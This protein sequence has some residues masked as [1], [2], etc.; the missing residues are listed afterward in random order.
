MVDPPRSAFAD[1]E[2]ACHGRVRGAW[3]EMDRVVT[4]GMLLRLRRGVEN[5]REVVDSIALQDDVPDDPDVRASRL[6]D[7]RQV[8]DTELLEALIASAGGESSGNRIAD[9]M[10]AAIQQTIQATKELPVTVEDVWLPDTLAPKVSDSAGRKFGK[11]V[12]RVVSTARK[13]GE[14]RNAPFQPVALRHIAREVVPAEDQA[15]T[16]ALQE[17][18]RWL[19]DLEGAWIKWAAVALPELARAAE[20]NREDSAEGWAA[21]RDAALGFQST[22]EVLVSESPLSDSVAA[23]ETRLGLAAGVLQA[24]YAVAGSFLLNEPKVEAP[25]PSLSRSRRLLPSF[26]RW[27]SAIAARYRLYSSLL[28]VLSGADALTKRLVDTLRERCLPSSE[29]FPTVA[30]SL[31]ALLP[32]GPRVSAESLGSLREQVHK[33]LEPVLAVVPPQADIERAVTTASN[34][35]VDALGALVRQPPVSVDVRSDPMKIPTPR[36][37]DLR[38]VLAQELALQSFDA[39][40]TERIRSATNSVMDG[41]ETMRDRINGLEDVYGFAAEAAQKELEEAEP[42]A[43]ERAADLVSEAIR[44]MA[45]SL[46]HEV[47]ELDSI[48]EGPRNRLSEEVS[49]GSLG[50]MDRVAAGG[51]QA[52]LLAARSRFADLRAQVNDRWGPPLDRFVK[53]LMIRWVRIRRLLTRGFNRGSEIVGGT[54]GEQGASSRTV[55]RMADVKSMAGE[56][57]L[58]YQRLFTFDPLTDSALLSGRSSEMADAMRRW[59]NWKGEDGIPLIVEGRQGCGVTSFINVLSATLAAED[60]VVK[61]IGLPHRVESEEALAALLAGSLELP[62]CGSLDAVAAAVFNAD[63]AGLP[64]IVTLDNLEHLFLRVPGGTDLIER[65]LTLLA[66]TAPRIF[67]IGGIS[68][69]AWQL[70]AAGEPTAVSQVGRLNLAP[71]EGDILKEAILVRHRRSGLPLTFEEPTDGRRL[72]KRKLL[73]ARDGSS[74]QEILKTD[75]FE[76]LQRASSGHMRLALFQWLTAVDFESRDGVLVHAPEKPNFGLLESLALTQSFTLK[77][78]LEHRSLTLDEHD[79]IFRLPRHESFQIFESLGNRHLIA[80]V[81]SATDGQQ[82]G[83]EV[84]D[85]LRYQVAPVLAGA[86]INHLTGRNIV[87]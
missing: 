76:Q 86:M 31:E 52:Q 47:A 72:L 78:F 37:V 80:P 35:T 54:T 28:D 46:R 33:T 19:R 44:S 25:F 26:D 74:K 59:E 36:K 48:V 56:L 21:L 13:T 66:E 29:V 43:D 10:S 5:H 16:E 87:H 20:R 55:K 53:K 34:A 41:L 17:W 2:A 69:S 27:E 84:T 30:T 14:A 9:V 38:P 62:D 70:I 24:E 50:L 23:A 12:A 4:D 51:V 73:R 61:Q 15:L 68:A 7:Y 82:T 11:S 64:D 85:D 63:S 18:A 3:S 81:R 6:A 8:V 65:L 1:L 58:V 77:A 32:V 79:R 42:E 67:W 60:R 39:L 83:S 22:L 40:R 57:P 71:L 49:A 75:F 45:E